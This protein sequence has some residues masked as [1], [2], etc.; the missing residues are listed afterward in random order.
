MWI[1]YIG[2][3]IMRGNVNMKYWWDNERE[4]WKWNI[5]GVIMT[6]KCEY[7]ILVGK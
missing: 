5:G 4:M 3:I 1:W 6:G 2:G 7:E